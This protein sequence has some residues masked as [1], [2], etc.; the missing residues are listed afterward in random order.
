MSLR[1]QSQM[2][3]SGLP[4][5][6]INSTWEV[7]MPKIDISDPYSSIAGNGG[8]GAVMSLFT[9]SLTTYQ[10]V[11]EQISFGVTNF[12]PQTR[13][14]RTMW[15]NVP[16]DIENYHD[17]NIT[18]FCSAGMLTQY[19]MAAWRSLVYNA[20]G[21]Y[22]NPMS[23]YKKNIEV[24]IYG[25]GNV[26]ITGL[27]MA[28]FTLQG[29]WPVS[30]DDYKLE[31]SDNPKRLTITAKFKVDKVVYAGSEANKAMVT[32]LITSPTS[33]VD[34]AI[35]TLFNESSNYNVYD[36]YGYEG[37]EKDEPNLTKQYEN[38][39]GIKI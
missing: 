30:Q 14:V 13:R 12:K 27:A 38:V 10:P 24:F 15:C 28:H 32:E 11:V 34:K 35:T 36:T 21:E 3:V 18:M 37:I 5:E 1:F 17:V 29:C 6:A 23:V 8:I 22:Y 9:S 2:E 4:D 20:E 7:L 16:E 26:G 33:I 19:Y 31:Y 25:P 39:G